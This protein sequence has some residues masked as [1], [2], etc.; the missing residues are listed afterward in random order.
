MSQAREFLTGKYGA[1]EELRTLAGG[2]WSSAYSFS[3][4]G[5]ALVLRLGTNK[6][7][8]EAE[9]V[10]MA[11]ATPDLPVPE[12]V[13]IGEAFDMVYAISVRAASRPGSTKQCSRSAVQLWNSIC[14][15]SRKGHSCTVATGSSISPTATSTRNESPTRRVAALTDR[16]PSKGIVNEVPGNCATNRAAIVE[17]AGDWYFFYHNGV[18][19]GGG[20]HRR[21]VCV[22][23]LS[24]GTDGKMNRV[25]MT[26]EGLLAR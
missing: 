13:E 14:W 7:W 8:F 22:D 2:F 4:A 26:T 21:S 3:H 24:Y 5:R 20:S 6:D 15:S 18:L 17:F 1:I 16:G 23:R 12:V 10:A 11:F 9:R 19:P 25:R